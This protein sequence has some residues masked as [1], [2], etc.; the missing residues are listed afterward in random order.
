MVLCQLLADRSFSEGWSYRGEGRVNYAGRSGIDE[1]N[2]VVFKAGGLPEGRPP[3][4]LFH[5]D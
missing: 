4:S 3:N 1:G 5:C 2:M